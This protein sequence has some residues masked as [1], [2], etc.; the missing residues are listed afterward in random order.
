M[1]SMTLSLHFL[2]RTGIPWKRFILRLL[3][4][5]QVATIIGLSSGIMVGIFYFLFPSGDPLVF[6]AVFE[7]V[8]ITMVLSAFLGTLIPA[9]IHMFKWDPK[10][11]AGPVVLMFVDIISTLLY[12]SIAYI[13][14]LK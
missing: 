8:F 4:D 7:S 14:L 1:Q 10:V 12:L 9:I 5:L 3:R 6:I 13:M 2:S 11:A